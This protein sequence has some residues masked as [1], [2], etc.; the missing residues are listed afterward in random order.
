MQLTSI[1]LI[2]YYGPLIQMAITSSQL[3]LQKYYLMGYVI[4]LCANTFLNK[5]LKM[6]YK[7]SR[8]SIAEEVDV[9]I[10]IS[11][12]NWFGFP[13]ADVYGMPSGHAQSILY[14]VSYLYFVTKSMIF[15]IF[16]VFLSGVTL[17]QRWKFK[18]HSV[19]QLAIGS[20]V[21]VIMGWFGV[22]I[23]SRF[24]KIIYG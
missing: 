9:P 3:L 21:G 22:Y 17:Y 8:P 19:K 11:D 20:I 2:G 4:F 18:R 16:G 7:E 10:K 15:L 12:A 13:S 24:L 1:D 23:T 14:S 6:H 5:W